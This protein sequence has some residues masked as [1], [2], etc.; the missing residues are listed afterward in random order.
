MMRKVLNQARREALDLPPMPFLGPMAETLRP[1]PHLYGFSPRVVPRP[2][3]WAD[4]HHDA[5]V[6]DDDGRVVRTTSVVRSPETFALPRASVVGAPGAIDLAR[7]GKIA[8]V[9]P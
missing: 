6:V 3:D 4:N 9:L 7:E 2:R 8:A 5:V 1:D